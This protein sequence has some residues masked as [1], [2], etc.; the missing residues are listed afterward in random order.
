MKPLTD[1]KR[2]KVLRAVNHRLV[3]DLKDIR[4]IAKSSMAF[5]DKNGYK[6]SHASERIFKITE[7]S[8]LYLAC[9]WAE[10]ESFIQAMPKDQMQLVEVKE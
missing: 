4:D 9:R 10:L 1:A 8:M 6:R 7:D 3:N 5:C 2:I